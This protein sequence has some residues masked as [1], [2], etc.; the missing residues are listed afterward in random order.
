M[1]KI[2]VA[3]TAFFASAFAILCAITHH[4]HAQAPSFPNRLI[5]VVVPFVPGGGSDS[6]ARVIAKGMTEQLGQ[7]VIVE[8]RGGARS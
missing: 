4:A 2:S 1:K 5:K 6:V 3:T 7:S 8:N